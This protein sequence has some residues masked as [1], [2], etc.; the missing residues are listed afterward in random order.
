MSLWVSGDPVF[1][2]QTTEKTNIKQFKLE[3]KKYLIGKA[4]FA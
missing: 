4:A 2:Y 1:F 3:R